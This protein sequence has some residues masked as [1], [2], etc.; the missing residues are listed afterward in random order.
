MNKQCLLYIT[1][2]ISIFLSG[3]SSR[4]VPAP[5]SSLNNN[6]NDLGRTININ[7]SN[8]KVQRGDT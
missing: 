3:C 2:F 6:V 8:Y 5:V 4:H 7:G 1:I